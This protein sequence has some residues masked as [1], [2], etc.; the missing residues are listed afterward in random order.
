VSQSTGYWIDLQ[1]L[2]F[3]ESTDRSRWLQ[4]FP[5]GEY[6]HPIYGKIKMDAERATRMAANFA[7]QIRGQELDVDYDHKESAQGGKAAGWFKAMQVR[8]DGLWAQVEWTQPAFEAIAAGEYRYFSPEFVD[9]WKH[10]KTGEVHKDV[11]F[12]GALTN[13]PFLKDILPINFTEVNKETPLMDPK[14]LRAKLGLAEDA[15]DDEVGAA[16]AVLTA[17]PTPTDPPQPDPQPTPDPTPPQPQEPAMASEI[18]EALK[19]LSESNP[20][21]QKL[22]ETLSTLIEDNKKLNERL[23]TTE[24]ALRLAEVDSKLLSFTE[25]KRFT[26]PPAVREQVK[27]AVLLSDTKAG[28]KI[29]NVVKE[30]AEAGMVELGERGGGGDHSSPESAVKAFTDAVAKLQKEDPKLEYMAAVEQVSADHPELW[31]AYS[32]ETMTLTEA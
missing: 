32:N 20:E 22:G 28:E 27:E 18:V 2:K 6:L 7:S 21:M 1:P 14:A 9:E 12:G 24:A 25:G 23:G 31:E 16:L 19:K 13:R 4:I 10:P 11:I 5:F 3:D 15:T 8:D 26:L 17:T 29:L 30:L